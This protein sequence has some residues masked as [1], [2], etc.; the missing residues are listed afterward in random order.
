LSIVLLGAGLFQ[1]LRRG[2]SCRRRSRVEIAIWGIVVAVVLAV[3]CSR[4]NQR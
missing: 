2:R 1:I 3:F 4:R